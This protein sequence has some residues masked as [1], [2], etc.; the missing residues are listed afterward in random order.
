M[1]ST[2]PTVAN[3]HGRCGLQHLH[4]RP[5][6]GPDEETQQRAL[7]STSPVASRNAAV[8]VMRRPCC[9]RQRAPLSRTRQPRDRRQVLRPVPQAGVVVRLAVPNA[10]DGVCQTEDPDRDG[11]SR[12]TGDPPTSGPPVRAGRLTHVVGGSEGRAAGVL[13]EEGL[14]ARGPVRTV[15]WAEHGSLDKLRRRSTDQR[16]S[17]GASPAAAA[18]SGIPRLKGATILSTSA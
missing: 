18:A 1:Q 14:T 17:R 16:R 4:A 15:G 5:P 3:C 2:E 9:P 7:V 10:G 8:S 11:S 12:T 6:R 13:E